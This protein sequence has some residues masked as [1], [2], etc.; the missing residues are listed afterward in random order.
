MGITNTQ[1]NAKYLWCIIF[2]RLELTWHWQEGGCLHPLYRYK[3]IQYYHGGG[4]G[5][6]S[7]S[8]LNGRLSF[9]PWYQETC[10]PPPPPPP[11]AQLLYRKKIS[12]HPKLLCWDPPPSPTTTTNT[13][14]P[15]SNHHNRKT[16]SMNMKLCS[17][18][19]TMPDLLRKSSCKNFPRVKTPSGSAK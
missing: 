7:P 4:H 17:M 13:N 8:P 19:V 14:G 10:P 12:L 2:S 11:P 1:I 3:R 15:W 5:A 9:I 16:A 6:P 18:T